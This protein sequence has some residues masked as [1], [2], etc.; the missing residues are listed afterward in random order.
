MSQNSLVLPTTGT[1]S[2]LVMT[3][4]TNRALDTLNTL[5]SGPSAP[6]SPEAGQIWHDTTAN[7]IRMLS[8]DATTW[9]PLFAVNEGNYYATPFAPVFGGFVNAFRNGT[10]DVWQRGTS[11]TVASGASAYSADGWII[12]AVGAANGWSQ[13]SAEGVDGR[14]R[15]TLGVTGNTGCTQTLVE[16]RIE[17]SLCYPLYGTGQPVTAQAVIYNNTGS[18]FTPTLNVSHAGSVDNWSSPVL[19]L[20]VNLQTCPAGVWTRV[21]YTFLPVSGSLNGLKISFGFNSVLTSSGSGVNI[22]ALDIRPTPWA[23]VGLNATPPLAELRPVMVETALCQRY[24]QR[25]G[26][27]ANYFVGSGYAS[28]ATV[29]SIIIPVLPWTMRTTPTASFGSVSNFSVFG[30]AFSTTVT[31]LSFGA[32]SSAGGIGMT[33]GSSG[34]VTGP[35]IMQITSASDAITLSAEL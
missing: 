6:S 10:M 26:G 4:N 28:S 21:S 16:Q 17:S 13:S 1:V 5:A 31:S 8:Q 3:Q 27:T 15:Y 29:G 23:S 24:F 11:G 35:A 32:L 9:I 19:D 25:I 14:C 12:T 33:F 22:G 30:P 18:A 7:V 34:M 20:S 2:G